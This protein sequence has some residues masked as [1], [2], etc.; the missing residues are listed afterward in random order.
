M[1]RLLATIL[2]ACMLAGCTPQSEPM[3]AIPATLQSPT[4]QLPERM[5]LK[6]PLP[7]VPPK[8][9]AQEPE[10]AC[11]QAAVDQDYVDN[12]DLV[13]RVCL[14]EA[15]NQGPLGIQAIAQVIHDRRKYFPEIFGDN[16]YDILTAK[17]Q[18]SKPMY[19][20]SGWPYE[21][22]CEIVEAVFVDEVRI[23]SC[24]VVYFYNPETASI[25]GHRFM[26]S[27]QYVGTI[28]D[29]EFRTEWSV[30]LNAEPC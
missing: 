3:L 18:F 6:N 30:L 15:G 11:Q 7:H 21:D 22:A 14:A 29:H 27:K 13:V 2:A 25:S 9:R 10:G 4:I 28:G 5:E 1:K 20:V 8:P 26:K 23:W 19:D 24:P 16:L 12:F 17:N